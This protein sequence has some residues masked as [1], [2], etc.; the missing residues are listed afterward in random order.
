MTRAA[1]LEKPLRRLVR[2]LSAPCFPG[3]P[4]GVSII[5]SFDWDAVYA[6]VWTTAR[7]LSESLHH[8]DE[9]DSASPERPFVWLFT[10]CGQAPHAAVPAGAGAV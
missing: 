6:V 1:I 7:S 2:S 10:A 3:I 5:V 4:Q 8:V 9:L